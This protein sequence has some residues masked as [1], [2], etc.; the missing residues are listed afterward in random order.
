MHIL[1]CSACSPCSDHTWLLQFDLSLG[2]GLS[3]ITYTDLTDIQWTQ[4]SQ[5]VRVGGLGVCRVAMLASSAFLASAASTH[6][7]QAQL[8]LNCCHPAPDPH[9]DSAIMLWTTS[10]NIPLPDNS[11]AIKQHAWDV[12]VI[13]ADK[14][15]LWTSLTDSHNRA[16]LLSVSSPH[17]GD[18]LHA[19]PVAS[20]FCPIGYRDSGLS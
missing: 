5:P 2:R 16:R 19:L 4:A 20:C 13:T 11:S 12:P 7:L 15:S 18:W 8:L 9:F 10:Y 14:A 3:V 6:D 17:S 1:R